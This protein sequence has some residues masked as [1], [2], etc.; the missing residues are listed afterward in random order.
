[1]NK[2]VYGLIVAAG[3]GTRA[4][5]DNQPFPKQ[6]VH[7]D[8]QAI[9]THILSK[10]SDDSR[11]DGILTV[12]H[13][14][15]TEA[16]EV[17]SAGIGSK[18][19]PPVFGADTRQGSVYNGLLA[20]SEYAPEY[21][22]IHDGAR[23]CFSADLIGR[24]IEGLRE[25][26]VV[27]PALPVSDT[28]KKVNHGV[29]VNT[30]D[31]ADLWAAQ[32]PQSFAFT[33]IFEAHQAAQVLHHERAAYKTEAGTETGNTE[34]VMFTDDAS[35]AEWF[36]LD[37]HIIMG[38]ERNIKI[39]T[40]AD[41]ERGESYLSSEKDI[42]VDVRV[43]HGFDV[44]AFEEGD[45]VILC[46][47]SIPFDKKLKGHSDA[48]VGFHALTDAIYGALCDGDIG[49]H[50]PPSDA[51][52]AGANSDIFLRHAAM[53]VQERGGRLTHLD[54]TLICEAPKIGPHCAVMKDMI[55]GVTGLDPDRISV[56]ATTTERLG[57]NG[58]G[59]GISAMA[60]ATVIF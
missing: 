12:I 43:G 14:D 2:G 20:L 37:V 32:T 40:I 48:D 44:H 30:V 46:G 13:P 15:D 9:L 7:L 23:P 25:H 47:V 18:L 16:Y 59:E 27:L 34:G 33:Q 55:A 60:T 35:I 45:A 6:Y 38:E 53:L 49:T 26:K 4:Q 22:L 5:R 54:V 31:R 57:F 29:V 28:I 50:F 58:R 21:V 56:K 10:M 1:M 11:I 39:T 36:G 3:R 41:F 17:A 24:I 51:K 52:W 42:M 8:G 19:L